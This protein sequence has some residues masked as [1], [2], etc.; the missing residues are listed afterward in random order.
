MV[1]I[2]IRTVRV[3]RRCAKLPQIVLFKYICTV[4]K[5]HDGKRKMAQIG[6]EVVFPPSPNLRSNLSAYSF[7]EYW[8]GLAVIRFDE[9]LTFPKIG[10]DSAI[11]GDYLEYG[12]AKDLRKKWRILVEKM[13]M[14]LQLHRRKSVALR[15]DVMKT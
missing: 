1:Q 3:Y 5:F 2:Y 11:F 9:T 6:N 7:H 15:M 4:S 13:L 14:F 10:T 12:D 8:P